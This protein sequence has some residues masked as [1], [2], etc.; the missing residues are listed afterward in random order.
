MISKFKIYKNK[1]YKKIQECFKKVNTKHD[2]LFIIKNKA[3]LFPF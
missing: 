1:F 3:I 2:T